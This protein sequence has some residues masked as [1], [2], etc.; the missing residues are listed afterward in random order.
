MQGQLFA[1]VV[2]TSSFQVKKEWRPVAAPSPPSR[3]INIGVRAGRNGQVRKISIV[4]PAP[5]AP[6]EEEEEEEQPP[7]PPM[8]P[9]NLDTAVVQSENFDRWLFDD[10]RS[11]SEHRRHLDEI[12]QGKVEIACR[13]HKLTGSQRAKLRLAGTG[14]IKR[15]FDRVRSERSSRLP[16]KVSGPVMRPCFASSRSRR[17]TRK[18]LRRRLT[19]RQVAPDYGSRPEGCCPLAQAAWPDGT[20]ERCPSYSGFLIKMS[21]SS[22]VSPALATKNPRNFR[23]PCALRVVKS[24]IR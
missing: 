3:A 12:L 14:D 22:I 23:P 10:V 9:F 4:M 21:R 8:V 24:L 19:L 5:P 16:G 11:E 6:V 18:R 13:K 1:L 15:F 17:F 7:P 20:I 2:L